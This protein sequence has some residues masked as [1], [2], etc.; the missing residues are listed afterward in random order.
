M[1]VFMD[2]GYAREWVEECA[3]GPVGIMSQLSYVD[4]GE[5]YFTGPY[6]F[7]FEPTGETGDGEL[8]WTRY[9]IA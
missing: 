5:R 1:K 2:I 4:R 9:Q 3:A 6:L 7:E 8:I